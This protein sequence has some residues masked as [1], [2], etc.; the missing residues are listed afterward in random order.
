MLVNVYDVCKTIIYKYNIKSFYIALLKLLLTIFNLIKL[1]C[2][3]TFKISHKYFLRYL[4]E[5]SKYTL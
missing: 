5:I 4:I 3:L 2:V 1:E